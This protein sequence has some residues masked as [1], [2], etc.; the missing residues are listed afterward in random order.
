M[1][2]LKDELYQFSE[3]VHGMIKK[4]KRAL[5]TTSD[6]ELEAYLEERVALERVAALLTTAGYILDRLK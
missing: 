3:N 5:H 4:Q 1:E 6:S 2:N